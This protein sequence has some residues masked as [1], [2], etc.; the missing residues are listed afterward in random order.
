MTRVVEAPAELDAM[1]A[2]S[3]AAEL[4]L[5]G[6]VVVECGS[7]EFIDSSGLRL[8]LEAH[9]RAVGEGVPFVLREPSTV[10]RRLLDITATDAVFTIES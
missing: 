8:L 6:P 1:A 7:V 3:F 4:A 9:E 5:P 2:A 10:V